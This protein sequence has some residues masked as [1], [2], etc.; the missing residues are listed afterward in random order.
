MDSRIRDQVGLEFSDIDVKG[1]IES[2]RGGQRGD[3]LSDK[4][5]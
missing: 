4:S 3:N 5:V 1:T 2:Q